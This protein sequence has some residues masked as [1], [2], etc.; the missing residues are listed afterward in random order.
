MLST[1]ES[2]LSKD[3]EFVHIAVDL[4]KSVFQV[5]YKDPNTGKFINSQ[6]RRNDFKKFLSDQDSF[7]KHIYVESCGACQY[8]C[9]FAQSNG[10]LA[11]VI[12]ASA[13]KTFINNNKSD[14]NDAKAIWQLSFVPD[15][16]EIRVRSEENQVM[17]ML[18]KCREKLISERTKIS[19]WLRGQL[20]ELG[21]ITSLGGNEKVL[22]LSEK[23]VQEIKEQRKI[24]ANQYQIIHSAIDNVVNSINTQIELIDA[25]IKEYTSKDKLCKKF[26]S[27]PYIGSINA[28]A[29]SYVMEDPKFYKN[30]REFAARVGTTPSF[31]GTGGEIRI[32]GVGNKGCSVL[33]RTMYQPALSMYI[34][35][36][37]KGQKAYKEEKQSTGSEW[38]YDMSIR[39]PLK[40]V[41]CAICNKMARVAWAIAAD[42]NSEGYDGAKTSLFNKIKDEDEHVDQNDL[43]LLD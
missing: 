27:I 7:K 26:M 12:P 39:K 28:Y 23:V 33:K 22:A 34:R 30:G 24:W 11:T 19:N 1:T 42:D 3:N 32:L 43:E 36:R 17:G 21:E 35:T 20:Y 37:A 40:K 41:V 29:L 18:L 15:L 10:H 4:A 9:R 38:I 5:A 31:T 13:T 8:W 25:Y 14:C 2:I 16:K 6:Y